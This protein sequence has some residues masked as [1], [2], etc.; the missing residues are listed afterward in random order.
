VLTRV[1]AIVWLW[2]AA[3]AAQ[4]ADLT[5]AGT[6]T[7]ADHET[8]REVP[9][10]VPAGVR[11]ITVAFDYTGREQRAVIDIGLRD[12]QRF[13]GWSGGNKSGFTLATTDA[14]PSYLAGPLPPGEWKLVLGVPNLRAGQ[15]ARY[16]ALITFERDP[17]FA[18]FGGA[19]LKTGPG[20]YRGDLHLHTG[21][22]DGTCAS[23]SGKK[24]PCPAFKTL[25]AAAARGLDFIAITDH[26]TTSQNGALRELA[27]Y[28]D[29]LL[30]IPGREITTFQGHANV[31]GPVADIDFQLGSKRA[32]DFAAIQA[33][34]EKAGG[35]LS[36]NH[37][38]LPS[39]EPCMGCGWTAKGV[40]YRR[41][42][43]VE[44]ANGG[45]LAQGR[46][47]DLFSGVPFW[48]LRLDEG[49]RI[50]AIG[51]SDNHDPTLALTQPQSVGAPTTV[52]KAEALSQTAILDG[53]RAGA[54]FIDVQGTGDRLMEMSASANG[55]TVSM[56]GTIV[57]PGGSEVELKVR[58]AK[59]AGGTILY[60][61]NAAMHARLDGRP[62]SEEAT[63]TIIFRSNGVP[64]WIRVD[65]RGP[66]GKLWLI[67]NPIYVIPR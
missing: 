51:G 66:D 63:E 18:G 24:V 49:H 61:G 11:R 6:L 57:A 14:T 64:G 50:T 41:V 58:V 4:A 67:G 30:L 3:S 56:G 1:L 47:S 7:R 16:T 21:H 20:W 25:E 46:G 62:L 10:R 44:V 40:D 2:L 26:N 15:S 48:K 39:G 5:L 42:Q 31:F 55:Q 22:S 23:R 54:V 9:F 38:G 27:P 36:I 45:A 32:P 13:R 33:Q 28:F 19:P 37:P 65:V 17:T 52:V 29:N 60:S 59:A 12:P 53:I 35:V 43:A 34:V 8:Y